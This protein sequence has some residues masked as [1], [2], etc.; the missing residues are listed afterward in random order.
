MFGEVRWEGFRGWSS[1]L[2]IWADLIHHLHLTSFTPL[3]Q[4]ATLLPYSTKPL[5]KHKVHKESWKRIKFLLSLACIVFAT[6]WMQQYGFDSSTN[7]NLSTYRYID[8]YSGLMF[9]A[10]WVHDT[11]R[12]HRTSL[13]PSSR[14]EYQ[15]IKVQE[16]EGTMYQLN[17]VPITSSEYCRSNLFWWQN[18]LLL[19]RVY[20]CMPHYPTPSRSI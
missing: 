13:A 17:T 9:M 19:G 10:R 20:I 8:P 3:P 2:G 11:Y 15:L 5:L 4:N 6:Q 7:I 12:S 18:C 1:E 16:W 14:F